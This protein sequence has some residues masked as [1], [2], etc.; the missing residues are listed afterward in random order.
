MRCALGSYGYGWSVGHVNAQ[1][2]T[3]QPATSMAD[4]VTLE[5]T[6]RHPF[7]VTRGMA[8]STTVRSLVWS[9]LTMGFAKATVH[10]IS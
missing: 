8:R 6:D 9:L 2:A 4:R 10:M 7:C 1:H 5:R 3:L